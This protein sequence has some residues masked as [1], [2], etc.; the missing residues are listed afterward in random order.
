MLSYVLGVAL[1]KLLGGGSGFECRHFVSY[2]LLGLAVLTVYAELFSL[3]SAVGLWANIVL[4]VICA[5]LGI[6]LRRELLNGL[7]L[8]P[9]VGSIGF[10]VTL[11]LVLIFAYGSSHGIMHY[12][13][14]L[15]HGQSIR[16]I[17]ELGVVPGLGNLHTRL[18]YNSAAFP[19]T[20]LFSMKFIAGTSLHPMAGY[21]ALLTAVLCMGLFERKELVKPDLAGFIRLVAVYY[22]I[23]IFDEMVSP[24][25]DYFVVLC[26][27]CVLIL[28]VEELERGNQ[29][30]FAYA[31]LSLLLVLA[32][33]FKI[34]AFPVLLLVAYPAILLIKHRAGKDILK[35]LLSGLVMIYPFAARSTILSGYLVY[36]IVGIDVF[37]FDFKIPKAIAEYDSKEVQVYGRGHIDVGRF[38]ESINVWFTDWFKA[39]DRVN[40]LTFALSLVALL[41]VIVSLVIILVT[42]RY[43]TLPKLW[44]MVTLSICFSFWMLT[45]PNIRFGCIYLWTLPALSLGWLY[46]A[47]LYRIDRGIV[48]RALVILFVGY[49]VFALSKEIASDLTAKY[50]LIQQDYGRYEVEAEDIGEFTFYY[51]KEG[52]R[53]G[54][55]PFPSY[56]YTPRIELRGDSLKDG[57]RPIASVE[58]R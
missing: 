47:T 57:F 45:S 44:V 36:P 20:A 40:K 5:A 29:E 11:V 58:N 18:A 13:S 32:F 30:P 25:S 26:I 48:F 35:F 1:F 21:M 31:M 52:D 9:K 12:D 53:V 15:Y 19:L 42:K 55:E 51:P 7:K 22:L 10:W 4:I 6:L 14:D 2:L 39:L 54:Y 34:S 24:A 8:L 49:K 28:Y 43:N 50:I 27:L 16:W 56:P 46:R 3:F 41:I 38:D 37:A 33:C 17:E 23:N